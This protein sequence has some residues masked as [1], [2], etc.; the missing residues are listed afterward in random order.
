VAIEPF[1]RKVGIPNAAPLVPVR[2]IA[3]PDIG[4]QIAAAGQAVFAAGEP[5]RQQKAI[6]AGETAA[7]QVQIRQPDGT[8]ITQKPEVKGGIIYQQAYDKLVREKYLTEFNFDLQQKLDAFSAENF[9]DPKKLQEVGLAHIEGALSAVPMEFRDQATEIAFR[10]GQERFRTALNSY[11]SRQNA[12][13]IQGT[14]NAIRSGVQQYSK[15]ATDPNADP[16]EKARINDRI[17]ALTG[18]LRELGQSDVEVDSMLEDI[19]FD[20]GTADEYTLS[21]QNT[22]VVMDWAAKSID[23]QDLSLALNWLDGV[24]TTGTISGTVTGGVQKVEATQDYVQKKLKALFPKVIITSGERA[25]NHPLSIQNPKSPHNVVNGGRAIDVAPIPGVTFDEYVATLKRAGINVVQAIDETTPEAMK[26]YGSTG[27]HWHFSFGPT[28][29]EQSVI[30]DGKAS[31]L[32][33]FSLNE[34]FPSANVRSS[35]REAIRMRI[36]EINRIE[37]ERAAAEREAQ[38]QA[39][40]DTMIGALITKSDNGIYNYTPQEINVLNTSFEQSIEKFG[41]LGSQDG[42]AAGIDF[43]TK[44]AFMPNIMKGWFT[45]KL[46]DPNSFKPALDF[47]NSVKNLTTQSGS[48]MGDVLVDS[49]VGKDRAIFDAAVSMQAAGTPDAV[50]GAQIDNI[51]KGKSYTATESQTQVNAAMGKDAYRKFK[52]TALKELFGI[53]GIAPKDL[54]NAY[55][56]AFAANLSALGN[57]VEEAVKATRTQ[58]GGLSVR[59]PIFLSGVGYKNLYSKIGGSPKGFNTILHAHL[60]ELTINGKPVLQKVDLGNG[61]TAIPVVG[62]PKTTVKISPFDGNVDSIGRYQVYIYDPAKP[63]VLL[64]R[65]V[66]DF[67]RDLNSVIE[68]WNLIQRHNATADAQAAEEAARE[69]LKTDKTV[70]QGRSRPTSPF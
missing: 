54:S 55:D 49:L 16:V 42:R 14:V 38:T 30:K 68:R 70:A 23:V 18:S 48:N 45:S 51:L 37:A 50:I 61:R 33:F 22:P 25:E 21:V 1:R 43:L 28:T 20:I 63:K 39:R 35:L 27:P 11:T 62:G 17:I 52:F 5:E 67:S 41:G 12:S 31:E 44:H 36:S 58:L 47:F 59:N 57:N 6:E 3:M 4:G 34:M 60:K 15:L 29:N 26:K 10:E 53:E 66:V 24:N 9:N 19:Q 32:N 56:Q 8:L 40:L 46:R 7:A 65:F 13:L 64:H 69:R 2:T